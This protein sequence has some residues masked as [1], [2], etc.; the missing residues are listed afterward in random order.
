MCIPEGQGSLKCQYNT[1]LPPPITPLRIFYF[2]KHLFKKK[3]TYTSG[4][5]HLQ[6]AILH[7]AQSPRVPKLLGKI[8]GHVNKSILMNNSCKEHV[9][10]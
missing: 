7:R 8:S 1:S 5:I 9:F 4:P 3:Q 2:K 6:F 10:K